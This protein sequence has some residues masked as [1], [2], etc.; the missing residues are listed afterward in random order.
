MNNAI[1]YQVI[2]GLLILFFFYLTYMFTKTW[3]WLH[4]VA[5]FFVFAA[6]IALIAYAAMSNRTHMA[7]KKDVTQKRDAIERET[8]ARDQLLEGDLAEVIPTQLSIRD[9]DTRLGRVILD[10]G[11][12]WRNCFPAPPAGGT[13]TLTTFDAATLPEGA[14]PTPNRIS[15]QTV[16][17]AFV[18]LE[19]PAD[20]G[21]D[22]PEG[23]KLP[24]AY[25]GEFIA[26]AVT[27][28]TVTLTPAIPLLPASVRLLSREGVTWALYETMPVDSHRSFAADPYDRPDWNQNADER[29]VFGEMDVERLTQ[30]FQLHQADM[31]DAVEPVLA[32]Y[33]RDGKRAAEDD[34]PEDVWLK[35]R[36]LE[37][38]SVVVDSEATLDASSSQ[39]F[40]DQGLATLPIVKRGGPSELKEGDVGIFLQESDFLQ[41]LLDSGKVELV[42]PIYVRKLNNYASGFRNWSLRMSHL[43]RDIRQSERDNQAITESIQRADQQTQARR[44]EAA[45][46]QQDLEKFQYEQEQLVALLERLEELWKAKRAD[47]SRLYRENHRL[48]EQ[49]LEIDRRLNEQINRTALRSLTAN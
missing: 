14:T 44:D 3:R 30:L 12:V 10:R 2:G 21:L 15:E 19:L 28:T 48:H 47:L 25:V 37:D 4:V 6:S 22:L 9:L 29:A 23:T 7:W 11:R 40:Y 27:D 41:P 13:V 43:D 49:L 46:L 18:E 24:A 39:S 45:R 34:A 36:F 32:D 26:T 20:S 5:V 17:Y 35:V 42:E 1:I 33:L 31:G 8:A 16:L 38:H